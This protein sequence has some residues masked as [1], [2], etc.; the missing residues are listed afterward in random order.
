VSGFPVCFGVGSAEGLQRRMTKDPRLLLVYDELKSFVGKAK[1]DNSVLLPLT[2]TLFESNNFE[3]HTK[4]REVSLTGAYLSIMAASTIETYERTWDSSFQD[5]GMTNRLFIVPGQGHRRFA[6]PGEVPTHE[7]D[8]MKYELAKVLRSA[9]MTPELSVTPVARA[10]YEDWYLNLEQSIHTK[11]LDAYALRFM[12]LFA[13]NSC[14]QEVD[15]VVV[16][17]VIDLMNWELQARKLYDP[18]DA[19]SAVAKIEEKIRRVL[20]TGSR[21][22]RDL[23]RAVHYNRIGTWV[24]NMGI[25]NLVGSREVCFDKRAN[26]WRL[27]A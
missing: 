21:S 12:I 26:E 25:K 2:A 9:T 17:N 22:D 7:R 19:D 27:T 8:I 20:S 4:D 6:I 3:S 13:V 5:I 23:K 18:I 14:K 1:V 24:F 15:E 11:R 16:Q 10:L